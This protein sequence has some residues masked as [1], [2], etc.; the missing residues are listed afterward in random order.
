MNVPDSKRSSAL[1][2]YYYRIVYKMCSVQLFYPIKRIS[3]VSPRMV[4]VFAT[5]GKSFEF[6]TLGFDP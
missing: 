3:D 4:G 1:T 5:T 2:R 6:P